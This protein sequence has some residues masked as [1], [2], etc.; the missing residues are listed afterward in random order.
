MERALIA[1]LLVVGLIVG[2]AVGSAYARA[3]RGWRDYQTARNTVPGA[4][5]AA[6]GLI[7]AATTKIGMIALLLVGAVA[8]AA[9]GP[10]DD[11]AG[12][13]PGSSATPTA[14]RGARAGR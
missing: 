13:A 2:S 7:S 8:Y 6:V 14:T 3:R 12:P 4:R 1:A 10:D 5:R 11:R 9:A